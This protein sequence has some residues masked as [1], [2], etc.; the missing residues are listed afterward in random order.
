MTVAQ[1][2]AERQRKCGVSVVDHN[3]FEIGVSVGASG[4]SEEVE[5]S[6]S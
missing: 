5:R 6:L 2:G 3:S 1:R 4:D